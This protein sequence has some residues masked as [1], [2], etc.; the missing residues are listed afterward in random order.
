M[1]F[2]QPAAQA[3]VSLLTLRCDGN[4]RPISWNNNGLPVW[5]VGGLIRRMMRLL[6]AAQ[7][8]VQLKTAKHG[9][10]HPLYVLDAGGWKTVATHHRYNARNH[11]IFQPWVKET[12]GRHTYSARGQ[13]PGSSEV[14]RGVWILADLLFPS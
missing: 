13:Q 6:T 9:D 10:V 4:H 14:C 5:A 8:F 3:A 7:V 11:S 2:Y 1:N 12:E